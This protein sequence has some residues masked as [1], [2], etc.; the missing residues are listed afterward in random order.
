MVEFLKNI[1]MATLL[2]QNFPPAAPIESAA[3]PT[4]ILK[5]KKNLKKTFKKEEV[6]NESANQL[7]LVTTLHIIH[8]IDWKFEK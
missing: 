6:K 7:V 8:N 4:T 2:C 5:T 3:P 1:S